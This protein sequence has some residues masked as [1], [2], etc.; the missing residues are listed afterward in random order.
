MDS[1]ASI[2]DKFTLP[3]ISFVKVL[4]M[5]F[6]G[7][8]MSLFFFPVF[9]TV[10]P[11]QNTKNL[12]GAVGL[13]LL[14]M[15]LVY[16]REFSLP[17]GILVLM[18]LAALVSIAALFSTN[19]NHTQE[20]AY[21]SYVRT[22]VIW[23]SA[24]YVACM[25]IYWVHGRIDVPLVINYLVG[26]CI[27]QCAMALMIDFIP[28]V[29]SFV[30]SQVIQGQETMTEMGRLYGI[31]ASLDVAGGR[32]SAVLIAISVLVDLK[33]EEYSMA[34]LLVYLICFI[35][36][37]AIG[38]MIA[39]TTLI[40]MGIGIAYLAFRQIQG[41]ILQRNSGGDRKVL[42]MW[43]IALGLL[44]PL[45]IF[46]YNTSEQ[47]YDLTRFG[48]EGFFNLIENGEW[49]VA[50]NNRL[51]TMV[52]FPEEFRTWIV[53]DGYFDNQR[54]DINYLGDATEEGF[55]MGTDI[56]YLR[57]IF[58]FGLI[59]LV[60]ISMVMIYSAFLCADSFPEYRI[61]FWLILLCNF[62][63]WLKVSTDL[64]LVFCLFIDAAIIRDTFQE[65]E[66][67]ETPELHEE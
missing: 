51:E 21:A 4:A 22:V 16:K 25:M 58:Y 66:E 62:V 45:A 42:S 12:L 61:I 63:I 60:F 10:F 2:R 36:I 5:L 50:S 59:G 14:F 32:F 11:A 17:R 8:I 26:V 65:E 56:G 39:R 46:F 43:V 3:R 49:E 27:F 23:L 47:F 18:L 34:T 37:S 9:L 35:L 13:V 55:Y 7:I 48:F 67:E 57:F 1:I 54:S 15:T 64:F 28:A 31:G 24:A 33:K 38:N 29:K 44:I 20:E 6:A 19:Y 52:V 40:G 41:I 53:G 30:D